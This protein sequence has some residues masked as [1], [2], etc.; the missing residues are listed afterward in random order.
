MRVRAP[1][2]CTTRL[3]VPAVRQMNA[4]PGKLTRPESEAVSTRGLEAVAGSVAR[5]SPVMKYT[6]PVYRV[7]RLP[8]ASRAVTTMGLGDRGIPAT[9]TAGTVEISHEA[10]GAGNTSNT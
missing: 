3:S 10:R 2:P 6:F 5:G 4:L 7:C 8:K 1:P 9:V